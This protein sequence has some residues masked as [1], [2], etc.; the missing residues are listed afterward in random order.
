[1]ERTTRINIGTMNAP[2]GYLGITYIPEQSSIHLFA[3]TGDSRTKGVSLI[4]GDSKLQELKSLITKLEETIEEENKRRLAAQA[5]TPPARIHLEE[6]GVVI[7]LEDSSTT[8]PLAIYREAFE[9]VRDGKTILAASHISKSLAW[10]DN[11]GARAV[12]QAICDHQR[13]H[14]RRK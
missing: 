12:A 6:S 13:L 3:F 2:G 9:F 5:K 7:Q 8:I 4:L 10:I 11:E 14:G 1:M